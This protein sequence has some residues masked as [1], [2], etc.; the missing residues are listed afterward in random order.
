ME[1]E[2]SNALRRALTV[3]AAVALVAAA[4]ASDEKEKASPTTK[5]TAGSTS[6]TGST[7]LDSHTQLPEPTLE[8]RECDDAEVGDVA[9]GVAVSC[10]WL[11]VPEY[12]AEFDGEMLRLSVTVLHSTSDKPLPDPVVYL[13]GGP[14]GRGGSP[15][16]WSTTPFISDR[17]VI[18][19]DQRGTG[20]SDPNMECPEMEVAVLEA[21]S[22]AAP[23]EDEVAVMREAVSEC[24]DRLTA[25]GIDFRGF[26]TVESAADLAD[27][28]VALGLE[29]WNVLG[30]SYGSRLAQEVLRSHPDGVRSVILDSTYPM[31]EASAS[32]TV[33]GAQ[34]ALDQLADGCAADPACTSANGDL[35][36]ALDSIVE[37]YDRDPY[38]STV[39]LGESDGGEITIAITGADIVAGLFTAMYDTEMI[40]VLPAAIAALR[41]GNAGLIDVVALEGIPTINGLAEGMALSTNCNDAGPLLQDNPDV[42][43]DLMASPGKWSSLVTVFSTDLCKIW[44]DNDAPVVDRAFT[45][46][47][48][49]ELPVLILS[50]T[51]DPVTSTPEAARVAEALPNSTFVTFDRL[52][53]GIW[54]TVPCATEITLAYLADPE[55]SLDTSCATANHGD[56]E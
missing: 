45:D 23:F 46:P 41:D 17:D 36:V 18:V 37:T 43:A 27:L 26:S 38:R 9:K 52:G 19:W 47:V 4:C 48:D 16:Y 40:K 12:R 10:Y 7:D 42:D 29:E 31:D 25:D 56:Q 54:N 32:E 3:V 11:S 22:A 50:G 15:R 13:S 49:S 44:L 2:P 33:V 53:H 8:D 21:F 1:S 34:R 51:Y 30:V 24:R 20:A 14:G 35:R 6:S 39:D 5:A 55:A 28:R